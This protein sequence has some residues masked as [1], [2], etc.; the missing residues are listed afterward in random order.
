MSTKITLTFVI[1]IMLVSIAGCSLLPAASSD[2]PSES[3]ASSNKQMLPIVSGKQLKLSL[4]A[5]AADSTQQLAVGDVIAVSLE[6]NPSTGY[7]WFATSSDQNVIAQRGET[8]YNSTEASDTPI[9]GAPG[10]ETIYFEAKAAGTATIT[11]DY[12]RGWESDV[13][14][15]K[16]ITINFEVK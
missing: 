12:K 3:N 15:D 5:S 16:T 2:K 14:P 9:V 1:I 10:T 13:A 8:Q 4:D 7:G 11:L 6:S